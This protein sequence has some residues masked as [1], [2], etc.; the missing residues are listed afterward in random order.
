MLSVES[1]AKI[2]GLPDKR[3][4]SPYVLIS[5]IEDGLPPNSVER[6]A[7]LLAPYDAQFKYRLVPKATYERRKA[8]RRLSFDE[9]TRLARIARIWALALDV[10]Q[11]EEGARE[12]LF[13]PHAML[14]DRRPV[15]LIIQSEFG[16][17]LVI[18]VLG[19][20]KYG[21]AA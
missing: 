15:D 6:I 19:G 16:A 20:L 5:R 14:G 2:L 21:T 9:G 1:V 17:E 10:W 18:D 8:S 7:Q 3:P 13:R 12:F 11:T 4:T